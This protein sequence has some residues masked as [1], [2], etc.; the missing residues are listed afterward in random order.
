[1]KRAT[2]A[3]R[4]TLELL[5]EIGDWTY[6]NDL[7]RRGADQRGLYGM[8]WHGRLATVVRKGWAER[9]Q[10]DEPHWA[11]GKAQW[12]ITAAGRHA[13]AGGAKDGA[14]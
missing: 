14:A 12:R 10:A 11:G 2:P 4:Q 1:M 7:Y 6:E 5:A 3:Q 13:L 9:R 8:S